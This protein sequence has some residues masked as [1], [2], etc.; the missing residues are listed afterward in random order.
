M[1]RTRGDPRT[2]GQ[3]ALRNAG[4]AVFYLALG[5]A[6]VVAVARF[7]PDDLE[8]ST[9]R[10]AQN[11]V[12]AVLGLAALGTLW[13]GGAALVRALRWRRA[14]RW[15]QMLRDPARAALVPPTEAHVEAVPEQPGGIKVVAKLVG[16]SALAIGLVA[17][18]LLAMFDAAPLPESDN[19]EDVSP[20]SLILVALLVM[21]GV[22]GA[23]RAW[24]TWRISRA[25]TRLA[26]ELGPAV[27]L[28][29]ADVSL[30]RA[31]P[32]PPLDV[33]F[34]ES[35]RT[36]GSVQ[37]ITAEANS[38]GDP[39]PPILYL[40]LF[41]NAKGTQRFLAG[42]WREYGYVH[43]LRTAASVTPD[44]LEVARR[45]G[46][47]DALFI[48]SEV[49][50]ETV[51]ATAPRAPERRPESP[52]VTARVLGWVTRGRGTGSDDGY[53]VYP[54][55]QLLCHDAIWKRVVDILLARVDL[56]VLDLSGYHRE[57]VGTGYELQR[58]V[59]RF[60]I[61]RV[62]MLASRMSDERFL[63]AQVRAAWSQMAAG[64]PNA[65]PTRRSVLI[66]RSEF[67]D[68]RSVLARVR[69]RALHDIRV[70]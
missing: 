66:D 8:P 10:T 31:A 64:S 4:R 17:Y 22:A 56:V 30:R 59:D 54:A 47:A 35:G 40:R 18:G 3:A 25:V 11:V 29:D 50:L 61:E 70:P 14:R 68:D 46:S 57:H 32:I 42:P 55:R 27:P 12:W 24:S 48:T 41:D 45:A 7:W 44:E 34:V 26:E 9:E 62:L 6:V 23:W 58:V 63:E 33:T 65:G 20:G 39:P 13:F 60:P 69:Q 67:G 16:L 15:E 49:E 53:P 43:L 38:F 51:L 1:A 19:G 2:E 37:R 36:R 28:H 21:L 5:V 52:N